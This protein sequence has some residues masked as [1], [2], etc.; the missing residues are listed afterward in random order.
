MIL[1]NVNYKE[2]RAL[3]P[4]GAPKMTKQNKIRRCNQSKKH[5]ANNK[6]Q[7]CIGKY[8]LNIG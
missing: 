2:E 6:R 4:L 3:D 5:Y 7:L 1:F 8:R